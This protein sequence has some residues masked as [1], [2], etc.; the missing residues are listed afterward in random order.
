MALSLNKPKLDNLASDIWKSAERLRGKFKSYEYQSVILPIIVIRR[1]ECVLIDWRE[2]K[3]VEVLKSRPK[4]S[5]KEL[6]KLVKELELNPKQSPFSN[7]TDWTLR[8]VYEE[9]HALLE[10]NFRA[11]ISGFSKNVDD[12][13]EHFNYRATI[14]LMVKNNRLAPIL[15]QYKE[16]ALG[17]DQL[18]GLE[19]G[20]IYEELLRRFSEQSGDEAGEHFTPREVIRLM[21]ELLD[22]P[23]PD[24]HLSIYDPA[25]GTGG[26]L[27]VAKEHLLERADTPEERA[28]VE[29]YV[30]VH[31]QELSPTNYAVCQADL[32]I[33]NDRQATVQLGNSLIPHVAHSREPGDQWPEPKWRFNRMLS[34]PPFGVTWGGKDGYEKEARKLELTRYKAGMPRVNDGALLFLQTMLAKM[35]RPE[36]GG[37]RIAIIFNGSP[38]SN[39]DCG[40]PESEIRRWILENDWL[41]AIVMLPGQLFYNTPILTYVWLLRND[42]PAS[43]KGRVMLIDARQQFEKEPISFGNKRNRMTALHRAWIEERYTNGWGKGYADD[44]VTIFSREQF[45]YHKVSVVFWQTDEIDQPAVLSEPYKKSFSAANVA[46]ELEFHASE[47]S[48]RARVKTENGEQLVTLALSPRDNAVKKFKATFGDRTAIVSVD[49]THRHYVHDNEYIPFGEDIEAFL[50]REI[51]KTIVRWEDSPHLGYEF[52]PNIYFYRYQRPR[53]AKSLL[54]DFWTLEKKAEEMIARLSK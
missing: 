34:N 25:S 17:P 51:S 5:A 37:S 2:K 41:D 33:K 53:L 9:D 21:V 30:T 14:G 27:S 23:I 28:R 7:T 54:A 38:L 45:A 8:S 47:L 11:Y 22:I 32:L 29:K 15:N 40:S 20:Y 4:L 24:K 31:G 16:L 46:G 49:W 48:F 18:S 44:Q 1:L 43:H 19:M 36:D 13:I 42:K 39:G 52:R 35:V 10:E 26:M 12:I 6:S 3:A 50:K